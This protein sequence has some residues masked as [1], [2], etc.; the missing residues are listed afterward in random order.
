MCDKHI[1]QVREKQFVLNTTS[2]NWEEMLCFSQF[3]NDDKN[4]RNEQYKCL[5]TTSIILT[6]QPSVDRD[7]QIFLWLF[8]NHPIDTRPW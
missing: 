3:Q 8:P 2:T 6:K 7:Y 4:G 1:R 5:N